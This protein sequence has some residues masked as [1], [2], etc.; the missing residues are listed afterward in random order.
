MLDKIWR[1][2][3]EVAA[4]IEQLCIL[5]P[6]VGLFVEPKYQKLVLRRA[7]KILSEITFCIHWRLHRIGDKPH[8]QSFS[9]SVESQN[10][11]ISLLVWSPYP[12]LKD[13]H[14][15]R[16]PCWQWWHIIS[17]AT[18]PLPPTSLQQNPPWPI[19]ETQGA[20]ERDLKKSKSSTLICKTGQ[21]VNVRILH[22]L[23]TLWHLS[24]LHE[25]STIIT[26]FIED[27]RKPPSLL[28]WGWNLCLR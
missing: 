22:Y 4:H 21:S 26:K 18:L 1:T 27:S 2:G 5:Y 17:W 19:A 14:G 8:I 15:A 25:K 9:N 28:S 10:C 3:S 23:K 12:F 16:R 24:K 20:A 7:C 13:W 6:S 11:F